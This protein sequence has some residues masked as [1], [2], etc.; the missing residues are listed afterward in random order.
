M[1][2]TQP[3]PSMPDAGNLN[4]VLDTLEKLNTE[5]LK[6]SVSDFASAERVAAF[7]RNYMVAVET[8]AKQN[9]EVSEKQ[10][11]AYLNDIKV[12]HLQ[13]RMAET[14][15]AVHIRSS[16]VNTLKKQLRGVD[17]KTNVSKL[18]EMC[19]KFVPSMVLQSR[20]ADGGDGGDTDGN[21]AWQS[22]LTHLAKETRESSRID[23][24]FSYMTYTDADIRGL[25]D[26]IR[27]ST[28]FKR[29]IEHVK[30]TFNITATTLDAEQLRAVADTSFDP[31]E[32]S[33]TNAARSMLDTKRKAE[34]LMD[35]AH[36]RARSV[37]RG[38]ADGVRTSVDIVQQSLQTERA[39]RRMLGRA[40]PAC[41]RNTVE[42]C[43]RLEHCVV[44]NGKC[45]WRGTITSEMPDVLL[46]K[47]AQDVVEHVYRLDDTL[48]VRIPC[49]G[50]SSCD[51]CPG[52]SAFDAAVGP[53]LAMCDCAVER[54]GEVYRM[55][56]SKIRFQ[57]EQAGDDLPLLVQKLTKHCPSKRF[58]QWQRL[59]SEYVYMTRNCT[60]AWWATGAGKTALALAT[61]KR[62]LP[63]MLP[64]SSEYDPSFKMIFAYPDGTRL[65][66]N[67]HKEVTD[68]FLSKCDENDI[69][70]LLMT[71]GGVQ[72]VARASEHDRLDIPKKIFMLPI[73]ALGR[74]FLTGSGN[75]GLYF[76]RAARNKNK[77][78]WEVYSGILEAARHLNPPPTSD[79]NAV[80]DD[81]TSANVNDDVRNVRANVLRNTV[82]IMDEAHNLSVCEIDK[83][84]GHRAVSV[85]AHTQ[86]YAALRQTIYTCHQNQ[87]KNQELTT[88]LMTATPV[89]YPEDVLRFNCLANML[90]PTPGDNRPLPEHRDAD[91][92]YDDVEWMDK[93]VDAIKHAVFWVDPKGTVFYP[94][95]R[96]ILHSVDGSQDASTLSAS[97]DILPAVKRQ[98][99]N[100]LEKSFKKE[101]SE[102][103]WSVLVDKLGVGLYQKP[104]YR[105]EG[106][107]HVTTDPQDSEDLEKLKTLF[108]I[109]VTLVNEIINKEGVHIVYTH[110]KSDK[111]D[112]ITG[113]MYKRHIPDA[114]VSLLQ[115]EM[116]KEVHL[117]HMVRVFVAS[118][119]VS[120]A[121]QTRIMGDNRLLRDTL[122]SV[123]KNLDNVVALYDQDTF[124]NILGPADRKRVLNL[125]APTK[126]PN[127]RSSKTVPSNAVL[128]L[129][130]KLTVAF[131]NKINKH[132][133]GSGGFVKAVLIT[134]NKIEGVSF[135]NT[136]HLHMPQ[137]PQ[138]NRGVKQLMG[139]ISR[140]FGMC[141]IP[142]QGPDTREVTYHIYS[143]RDK[144]DLPSEQNTA[145]TT[146]LTMYGNGPC[147]TPG[148]YPAKCTAVGE[149]G[150]CASAD[151]THVNDE[152]SNKQLMLES[153]LQGNNL[154]RVLN[155]NELRLGEGHSVAPST[156]G[157]ILQRVGA[158]IGTVSGGGS[159]NVRARVSVRRWRGRVRF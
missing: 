5:T 88:I 96:K 7:F 1:S 56:L 137:S 59:V 119:Q 155:I 122:L 91:G 157:S 149:D 34:S 9:R 65:G 68:G 106:T 138:S 103:G 129:I 12:R 53:R 142:Y 150:L 147:S 132:Q 144:P 52:T 110:T 143:L 47:S 146:Q 66:D 82:L 75:V 6:R 10:Q 17:N 36:V 85:D 145:D 25:V 54:N 67:F 19:A 71:G 92:A 18:K 134:T 64:S 74:L 33:A 97:A 116:F 127:D 32:W 35:R 159:A 118:T 55:P 4:T 128:G 120:E 43:S 61:I 83:R 50:Q 37:A 77:K 40:R 123:E 49:N 133:K 57:I 41:E 2:D 99:K 148:E 38:I 113:N 8:V 89:L 48:R 27:N 124:H 51:F 84:D 104:F 78:K 45:K 30:S 108:P 63:R 135:L 20:G 46:N 156:I 14:L 62:F 23:V 141:D 31:K 107:E 87:T 154:A 152:C 115:A 131:F 11:Q 109:G 39:L 121:E 93:T 94:Q 69:L 136:R 76:S 151:K 111:N 79:W 24:L 72:R 80:L 158:F 21:R 140:M 101:Q 44:S 86:K 117:N 105:N 114:I 126:L 95:S 16:E 153:K 22:V 70:A 139:R 28:S 81:G 100:I 58:T 26:F 15:K 98:L 29:L 42:D 125:Y 112:Q 73:S 13:S 60:L 102:K 90:H 130:D 3:T